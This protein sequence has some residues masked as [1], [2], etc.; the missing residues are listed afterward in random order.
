MAFLAL[1]GWL[2][3]QAQPA[4]NASSQATNGVKARPDESGAQARPAS[5]KRD[6]LKELEEELSRPLQSL[7]PGSSLDAVMPPPVIPY[8][9]P[10]PPSKRAQQLMQ[11]QKD[12]IFLDEQELLNAQTAKGVLERAESSDEQEKAGLTPLEQFFFRA[13]RPAKTKGPKKVDD[14]FG[15]RNVLDD[16]LALDSKANEPSGLTRSEEDLMVFLKGKNEGK[17]TASS[18]PAVSSSFSD[19]FGLVSPEPSKQETL[20]HQA[21]LDEFHRLLDPAWQTPPNNDPASA[22]SR[23]LDH[24]T[25]AFT[26]LDALAGSPHHEESPVTPGGLAS[27][28][29]VQDQGAKIFALPSLTPT[30]PAPEPPR[31]TLPPPPDFSAPRRPF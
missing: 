26:P 14:P 30:P 10:A 6:R 25:R 20:E 7:R 22:L 9:P 19:V 1:S 12:W 28:P 5:G 4:E 29:S 11:E 13:N 27:L 23:V 2:A 18:S 31:P 17:K 3:C 21:R 15:L 16:E 24:K 8:V